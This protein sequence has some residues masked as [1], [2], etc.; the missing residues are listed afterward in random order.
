M[1]YSIGRQPGARVTTA[2]FLRA[3]PGPRIAGDVTS[4]SAPTP[5]STGTRLPEAVTIQESAD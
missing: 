1:P 4:Y 5:H 2:S 3:G